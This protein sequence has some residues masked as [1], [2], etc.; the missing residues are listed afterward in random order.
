MSSREI[1]ELLGARHDNVKVT[2]D[3]LANRGTI[4]FPASQEIP[5]ATKPLRV[6][7]L[8]KRSSLIVVAH[9]S[10]EFTASVVDRWQGLEA[11]LAQ[12]PAPQFAIPQTLPEALHPL[13]CDAPDSPSLSVAPLHAFLGGS[14]NAARG[15]C[16]FGPHVPAEVG[17]ADQRQELPPTWCS[18]QA[19]HFPQNSGP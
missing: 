6:Y 17:V 2:V 19:N 14:R 10:P 18:G 7:L 8:D 16:L 11:Q 3:R 1:A 9:L 4:E 15:S 13:P 12:P 5:T